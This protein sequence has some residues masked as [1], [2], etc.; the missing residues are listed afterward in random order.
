MIIV[1]LRIKGRK[2]IVSISGFSSDP[3]LGIIGERVIIGEQALSR[4]KIYR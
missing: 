2:V 4:V 1:G 3:G